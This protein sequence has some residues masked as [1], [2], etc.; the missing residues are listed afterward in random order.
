MVRIQFIKLYNFI[1]HGFTETFCIMFQDGLTMEINMTFLSVQALILRQ[2]VRIFNTP[3]S[4]DWL[5]LW[6][7]L[8]PCMCPKFW[9]NLALLHVQI[10]LIQI[11]KDSLLPECFHS[12]FEPSYTPP[13]WATFRW[14][15]RIHIIVSIQS[16]L[17]PCVFHYE[18][19]M[20]LSHP[21][22]YPLK[23]TLKEAIHQSTLQLHHSVCPTSGSTRHVWVP[24]LWTW[25]IWLPH[26]DAF[27][28]IVIMPHLIVCTHTG[29]MIVMVIVSGF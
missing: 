14:V 16:C 25:D 15:T 6:G 3:T 29:T 7:I 12:F 19:E 17:W 13:Q 10:W 9:R 11:G 21:H 5:T 26:T 28:F 22:G 20:I 24:K 27:S 8:P 18:P 2:L 4:K 23:M 1:I